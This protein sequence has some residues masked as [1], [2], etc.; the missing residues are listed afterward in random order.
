[1]SRRPLAFNSSPRL[2]YAHDLGV[3]AF[4]MSAALVLRFELAEKP[5]PDGLLVPW[6][7]FFTVIC[8]VVFPLFGLHRAIWRYT[9]LN[10]LWR[11]LQAAALANLL[12][13]P[14]LFSWNRLEEFPRSIPIVGT[15]F[16]AVGLS[17]GRIR[18]RG[19]LHPRAS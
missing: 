13:L 15:L 4:A 3:A 5:I 12:L 9:A 18:R 16:L 2:I 11:I 8:A 14:I 10:D 1:M 17:L 19:P 6:V 7:A